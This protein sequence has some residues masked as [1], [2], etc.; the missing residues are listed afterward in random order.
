MRGLELLTP[1]EMEKRFGLPPA[2]IAM[3]PWKVAKTYVA[4]ANLSGHAAVAI[5]HDVGNNEWRVVGYH[6]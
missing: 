1:P 4:V 2:R 6:D 3:M 5:I